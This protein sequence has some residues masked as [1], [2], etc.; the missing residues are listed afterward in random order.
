MSDHNSQIVLSIRLGSSLCYFL[1]SRNG[2]VLIDAGNA[3]KVDHLNSVLLAHEYELQDIRLIILTHTHHDHVGSLAELKVRT[4]ARVMVHAAEA[5]FLR[6]GQ[7]PLPSG[8]TPYTKLA[9]QV[10]RTISYG[11][12]EAVEPDILIDGETDLREF[13][14]TGRVLPTSGHTI[15][16]MSILIDR[17]GFVGDTLFGIRPETI[18]PPFLSDIAALKKSWDALLQTDCLTFYPGHGKAIDRR[19]FEIFIEKITHSGKNEGW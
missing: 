14:F 6:H 7:T 1:P 18:S 16:S 10:G 11:K 19:R 2:A 12:Y 13:G 9:V 3:K 4:G 8:T 17:K 5:D 15:G